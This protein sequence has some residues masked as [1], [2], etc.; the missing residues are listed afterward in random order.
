MKKLGLYSA[1]GHGALTNVGPVALL[2]DLAVM[3]TKDFPMKN[4][5]NADHLTPL[6]KPRHWSKR[7]FERS[8]PLVGIV[9]Q[10][11]VLLDWRNVPSNVML[12]IDIRRLNH[13][14]YEAK[15]MDLL[16]SVGL[17][18]FENKNPFELMDIQR[19]WLVS[20]KRCCW[21]TG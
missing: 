12:Q 7:W 5:V 14:E 6:V 17:H 15:A 11:C 20:P 8:L 13:Q 4:V 10:G 16:K 18:G 19:L 2:Q 21:P 1:Q 9:F 3:A